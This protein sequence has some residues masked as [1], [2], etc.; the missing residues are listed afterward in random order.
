MRQPLYEYKQLER[1][2]A[3]RSVAVIGASRTAGAFGNRVMQHLASYEGKVWA[4]NPKYDTVEGR[5]CVP[6]IEAID[7]SPDC[8]VITVPRDHVEANALACARK[9]VGGLVIFASGYAEVGTPE[10]IAQQQRLTGIAQEHGMPII[11]P[12]CIGIVNTSVGAILTFSAAPAFRKPGERAIGLISQS[13]A[14]AF[15]MA[16]AVEHGVQFSHVM[17]SGN[18][19]DVDV[20][21]QVAYLARDPDCHAIACLFEG[22]AAPT[23]LLEAARMAQQADKPLVIFKIASSEQGATAAASHTGSLAGS[24][25]VYRASLERLG[26]ILVD[27]FEALVETT[28]FFAK[29]PPP[30]ATGV[31]VIA[32]SGGG[33]IMCADKAEKHEVPLPQPADPTREVLLRH[34]PEFGSARNPCDVTAQVLTEPESFVA[35]TDALLGDPAFGALV[36]PAV[37]AYP[38]MNPR[39]E[40]LGRVAAE[41]GKISCSVWSTEWL[42]GPGSRE[43]EENP[44]VALFRSM[45]RCFATLRAWHERDRLGRLDRTVRRLSPPD[46]RDRAMAMLDSIDTPIL[47]EAQS[48]A[49]LALY[50]LPVVQDHRCQSADEAVAAAAATGYPVVMKAESPDIAHKTE[51]GVVA[52]DIAD[53]T[54]VRE[55][56]ARIIANARKYDPKARIDSVLVQPMV[57]AGVEIVIG[58]KV[59]PQFGPVVLVG[60]GGVLVEVL[61]DTAIAPAPLARDEAL[62]MLRRL[63]A[64]RLLDGF[65]GQPGAD[66]EALAAL[67]VRMGEVIADLGERIAEIDLNPVI[68]R[69]ERML[70][71]DAMIAQSSKG[72]PT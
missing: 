56:H 42:E 13:G 17:T 50:G 43:A 7:E 49:L 63:R 37:Y 26:V 21:D 23:R 27:N 20:A 57:P 44:N 22:M 1:L 71:V 68:C 64:G 24:D 25:A 4:V 61:R 12:N 66:R 47:T 36:F 51:A 30:T 59:D 40:V 35:C 62:E 16:Q 10:R 33:A 53:E 9:G 58:A 28:S 52:L 69:G 70:A 34:I 72:S 60:L 41:R 19:C 18:A 45:D 11:G 2:L 8:V 29:A 39:T 67:V 15:A 14:L 46:A 32:S 5:P 54:Q 31:A 38:T 3:P 65:R 48:K 6:T 55:A